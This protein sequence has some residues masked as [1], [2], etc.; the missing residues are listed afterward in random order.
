MTMKAISLAFVL[1]ILASTCAFTPI[2][3]RNFNVSRGKTQLD[4]GKNNKTDK[5]KIEE[6]SSTDQQ[7]KKPNFLRVL[8]TG[9]ED[10]VMIFAKPQ[11]DWSTGKSMTGKSPYMKNW[12]N[13]KKKEVVVSKNKI[14][15]AIAKKDVSVKGKQDV[16]N[17]KKSW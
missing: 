9:A 4:F 1:S 16:E 10:G 3:D 12:N 6:T 13:Y 7:K 2:H 8:L 11:Y 17:A 15:T 14:P 5:K